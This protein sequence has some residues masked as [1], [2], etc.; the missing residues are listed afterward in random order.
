MRRLLLILEKSTFCVRR[1]FDA[2]I[3]RKGPYFGALFLCNYSYL[4]NALYIINDENVEF[5]KNK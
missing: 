2:Y 3:L 1:L 5:S 4:H